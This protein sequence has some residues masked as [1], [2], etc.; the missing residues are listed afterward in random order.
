VSGETQAVVLRAH[1][2]GLLVVAGLLT[3]V[4]V[5]FQGDYPGGP[6]ALAGVAGMAAFIPAL[7][8]IDFKVHRLPN[9]LVLAAFV[10]ACAGLVGAF[11]LGDLGLGAIAVGTAVG[12]GSA[13][14]LTGLAIITSGGL[15]MGDIKWAGV[16]GLVLGVKSAMVGLQALFVV[17]PF[18]AVCALPLL[19]LNHRGAPDVPFSE[20]PFAYGPYL[21]AATFIALLVPETWTLLN[22]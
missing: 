17:A 5:A 16:A 19:W 20:K 8:Y 21:L 22:V 3:G 4:L 2:V 12:L 1:Q 18:L 7:A 13:S 10:T 15:G 6:V 11:A 14:F 9:V